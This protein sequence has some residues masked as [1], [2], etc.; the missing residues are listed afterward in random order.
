MTTQ[1]LLRFLLL[2]CVASVAVGCKLAVIVVEGGEVRSAFT[3][4]CSEGTIC[5][6]EDNEPNYRHRFYAYPKRGWYFEKWGSG[7]NF[8]CA[9]SNYDVCSVP[10]VPPASRDLPL[11]EAI[12]ASSETFYVMPIFRQYPV[13]ITVEGKEWYQPKLFI[14]ASWQDIYAICPAPAGE[15]GECSGELEGYDMTGWTWASVDD[16]N[17]LFNHYIGSDELG[18]GPDSAGVSGS[19][20]TD[21]FAD[22]WQETLLISEYGE[23]RELIAALRTIE[24]KTQASEGA[25]GELVTGSESFG[26]FNTNSTDLP[27]S[28]RGGW[29]YRNR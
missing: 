16:V 8:L 2:V 29:F 4:T 21:F 10:F 23:G 22:G 24:G 9:D 27:A 14:G 18:P 6:I 26:F 5:I 12:V 11:V 3:G 19:L 20:A 7:A 1:K 17:A 25:V 28:T 13:T 15:S